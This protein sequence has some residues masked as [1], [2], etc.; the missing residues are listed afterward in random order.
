MNK[1]SFNVLKG[2][3]QHSVSCYAFLNHDAKFD[4]FNIIP[5]EHISEVN[6]NKIE[7][8][9]K[10]EMYWIFKINTISTYRLNDRLEFFLKHSLILCYSVY[11]FISFSYEF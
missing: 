6:P 1:H 5:I 7:L 8:L 11:S 10:R 9:S 2:F 4:G 3:T